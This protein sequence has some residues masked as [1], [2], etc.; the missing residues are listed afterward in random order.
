MVGQVGCSLHESW[1]KVESET[2]ISL[3]TLLAYT[4]HGAESPHSSHKAIYGL[5]VVPIK[6]IFHNSVYRLAYVLE[7]GGREEADGK[8]GNTMKNVLPLGRGFVAKHQEQVKT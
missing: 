4:L 7:E 3:C 1:T 8:K 6:G 2:D 5:A